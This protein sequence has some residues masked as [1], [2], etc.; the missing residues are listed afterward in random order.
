MKI[1][2]RDVVLRD[3][4]HSDI[5]KM[6]YFM[7]EETEWN[8]WDAP[9]EPVA[10]D[11]EEQKYR[12]SLEACM[13]DSFDEP[14]WQLQVD[15]ADGVLIGRV[16]SY[17][18]DENYQWISVRDIEPEQSVY[19]ALGLDILDSRYWG[20]GLGTQALTAWICYHLEYANQPLFVQTW[21][22]NSRMIHLALKLGFEEQRR[23]PGIRQ[24]RGGSYDAVTFRLNLDL[25]HRFL[26]E[27]S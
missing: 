18:I 26:S 4:E 14:R 24:V 9:W 8:D 23:F 17:M 3:L 22:G 13:N 5:D 12:A 2:Y 10:D 25:F 21:S 19:R 1:K 20:C 16:N 11:F 7:T 27:N 6:V 15:T